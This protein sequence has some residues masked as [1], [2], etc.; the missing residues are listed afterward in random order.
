MKTKHLSLAII[1]IL[2]VGFI[3]IS[4]TTTP[5]ENTYFYEEVIEIEDWMTQP[6]G[7]SDSTCYLAEDPLEIEDWMTHPFNAV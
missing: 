7:Q 6:F 1:S 5:H 4:I 2:L 3:N